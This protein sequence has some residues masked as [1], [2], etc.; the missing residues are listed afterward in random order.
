MPIVA[1]ATAGKTAFSHGQKDDAATHEADARSQKN[2]RGSASFGQIIASM[3]RAGLESAAADA[4][5]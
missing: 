4:V 3:N 2:S 5:A 1:L